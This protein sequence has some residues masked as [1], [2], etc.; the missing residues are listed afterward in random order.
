MKA[1]FKKTMII[2]SSLLGALLLFIIVVSLLLPT[3][4]LRKMA[5]AKA[6][7]SLGVPVTIKSLGI[8]LFPV[9]VSLREIQMGTETS[10]SSIPYISIDEFSVGLKILP[11][12]KKE[13]AIDYIL[14]DKPV[15][16][17]VQS[18]V[19]NEPAE[20]PS[21][22]K[23]SEKESSSVSLSLDK[24][25]IV[26]GEVHVF[27]LQ[28]NS[29]ISLVEINETLAAKVSRESLINLDGKLTI[30]KISIAIPGGSIG[31]GLSFSLEKRLTYDQK[32]DFLKIEKGIVHLG[33]LPVELIGSIKNATKDNVEMD[34]L[35]RGGP[36]SVKDIMAYLPAK[37]FPQVEGVSSDGIISLNAVFKG[38]IAKSHDVV[39]QLGKSLDYQLAFSLKKGRLVY[40]NLPKPIEDI[41]IQIDVN[42]LVALIKNISA[43]SG[44]SKLKVQGSV[45]QY[46]KNPNM[47]IDA[48]LA[49]DLNEFEAMQ[50]KN[51]QVKMNG[52]VTADIAIKG[53]TDKPKASGSLELK[54]VNVSDA[55][56][57]LPP[58]KNLN[59]KASLNDQLV[60][61]RQLSL[62]LG[63]SDLAVSGQLSNYQAL[64]DSKSKKMASFEVSMN[65]K[66][67]NL[68]ELMVSEK[69]ATSNEKTDLGMLEKINGTIKLHASR[70]KF[71]KMDIKNVVG[72][73]Y[74][75]NGI[76]NLKQFSL[77]VFDGSVRLSGIANFKNIKQPKFDLNL[78]LKDI[79]AAALLD[80]AQN[81]NRYGNLAGFLTGDL[82]TQISF[83]GEL[84]EALNLKMDKLNSK[85]TLVVKETKLSNHPIQ[86]KLSTFLDAPS[87]KSV[88][89]KNWLQPF[90]I[91]GGKLNIKDMKLGNDDLHLD[92]SG[93]QALDGSTKMDLNMELPNKWAKGVKKH[94]PDRFESLL[95]E[96]P[97]S[98]IEVPLELTG[99]IVSPALGLNQSK[100]T[101]NLENRLQA[102]LQQEKSKLQEKA[103][104][105]TKNAIKDKA[106]QDLKKAIKKLF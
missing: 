77:D 67:L 57:E 25:K 22:L 38:A 54:S 76:F 72:N 97:D 90:E 94:I 33:E 18:E 12:I 28:G 40:P 15:I 86:N 64:I 20:S 36:T 82:S 74:L 75:Q 23:N 39:E 102:K 43:H 87:L 31:Q 84:D 65:S 100:M 85:G 92:V 11:L 30:G 58:V 55:S 14:I 101:A 51:S 98:K 106:P 63:Q 53:S 99:K 79:K 73:A 48:K 29:L 2:A 95:F 66:N 26:S 44:S 32:S 103:V 104:D 68:D 1:K 47:M 35:L 45:S 71:N 49:A 3:E 21:P 6:S 78:D 7:E 52:Q 80:Y 37:M 62:N 16:K 17:M 81:L 5:E 91:Q 42:P 70:V 4:K 105:K 88:A 83:Q 41:E 13:V 9:G 93:W 56:T 8:K 96:N 59:V 46:L 69:E 61:I 50:P 27:D 89:L 34:L 19:A 24:F 60:L 10:K